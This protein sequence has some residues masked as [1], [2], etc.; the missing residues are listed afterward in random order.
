[1][2]LIYIKFNEIEVFE[3]RGKPDYPGKILSEQRREPTN[4][5]HI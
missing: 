2:K 5:T 1:L 4:S 3:E